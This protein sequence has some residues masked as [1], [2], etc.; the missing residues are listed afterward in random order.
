M[1]VPRSLV[2]IVRQS[3][4][5]A[6]V[7]LLMLAVLAACGST[8][9]SG[10]T[11]TGTTTPMSQPSSG[12]TG[13]LEGTV[14]LYSGSTQSPVAQGTVTIRDLRDSVV[15]SATTDAKGY[16]TV[17]LPGGS[18]WLVAPDLKIQGVLP[19]KQIVTITAGQTTTMQCVIQAGGGRDPGYGPAT[20]TT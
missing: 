3:G 1:I 6:G 4:A 13:I 18:Y 5:K 7:S 14:V 8:L 17:N 2:R 19:Q 11:V 12:M 20:P 9:T 10:Q 15:A 16:F